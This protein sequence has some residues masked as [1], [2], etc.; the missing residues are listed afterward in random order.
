[1]SSPAISGSA[2]S[3]RRDQE[4]GSSFGSGLERTGGAPGQALPTHVP[5]HRPTSSA[6]IRVVLKHCGARLFTKLAVAAALLSCGLADPG[7]LAAADE[8]DANELGTDEAVPASTI[9]SDTRVVLE[10]TE[11]FGSCPVYSLNISGDGTVAYFGRKYVNVKGPASKQLPISDV[12][13]LVDQMLQADY[14]NLSVPEGCPAG[15]S[16]DAPAAK[17]SLTLKGRTHTVYHYQGNA[18]APA[19]LRPLEDAI[20]ILADS[21]AWLECD[22]PSGACCDPAGNPLLFPCN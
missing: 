5:T 7:Q 11:C 20:D 22:T 10:R 18:C 2:G 17:T 21:A 3:D 15:V 14:F 12:Q 1:M 8:V 9:D 4:A 6:T 13:A 16:T 19:G